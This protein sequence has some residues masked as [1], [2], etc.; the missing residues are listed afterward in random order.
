VESILDP[1]G[2]K[3]PNVKEYTVGVGS[4]IGTRGYVRG[5]IVLRNWDDFYVSV[6]DASTGRVT[7][8][9]GT[10][11]DQAIVQNDS[12]V[13]DREY[14]ALQMQFNYR[15]L[16]RLNVGGTYTW[17]R[18]VGNVIGESSGSGPEVGVATERAEYREERWNYPTATAR[19]R[20]RIA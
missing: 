4:M 14:T 9:Y 20:A 3:S 18:L 12:S 19:R 8:A 1:N 17:S 10:T 2:L 16:P 13:Y 7:D 15:F 5:D 11:Y 6:V